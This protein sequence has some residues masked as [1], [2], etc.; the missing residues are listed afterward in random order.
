MRRLGLNPDDIEGASAV[1]KDEP[2]VKK[3]KPAIKKA[4]KA[5]KETPAEMLKSESNVLPV[6]D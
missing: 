6:I 1:G 4:K 5:T 3:R 2:D